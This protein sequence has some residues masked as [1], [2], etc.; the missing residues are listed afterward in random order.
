MNVLD[1][2]EVTVQNRKSCQELNEIFSIKQFM[3][4]KIFTV[5]CI[6]V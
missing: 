6:T 5:F 2:V 4:N 1:G 3:K